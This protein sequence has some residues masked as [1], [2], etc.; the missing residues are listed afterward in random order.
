MKV[1]I[2]KSHLPEKKFDA[3]FTKDDGKQK[4]VP[5][6]AKFYSD[7]TKHHDEARKQRYIDRHEKH[8]NFNDPMTAGS[9]SRWVLWEKPTLHQGILEFKRRFKII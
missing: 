8:E 5:F 7:F 4:V 2:V 9:L 3:V 1:K 6:G